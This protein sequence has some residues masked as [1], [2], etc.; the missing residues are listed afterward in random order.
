MVLVE[1]CKRSGKSACPHLRATTTGADMSR[2]GGA[3]VGYG[4]VVGVKVAVIGPPLGN[5]VRPPPAPVTLSFS[6]HLIAITMELLRCH[7]YKILK[8]PAPET[9][10]C[11]WP[12]NAGDV[13]TRD[14]QRNSV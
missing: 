7:T 5:D 4:N 2:C 13:V 3:R 14:L 11:M 9:R 12:S 10:H 1:S 8:D 6:H